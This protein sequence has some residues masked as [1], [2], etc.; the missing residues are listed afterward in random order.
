MFSDDGLSLKARIA[1]YWGIP[2]MCIGLPIALLT[3]MSEQEVGSIAALL[4]ALAGIIWWCIATK[5]NKPRA[6]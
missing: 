3:R 1:K 5:V 2:T 4:G 6:E